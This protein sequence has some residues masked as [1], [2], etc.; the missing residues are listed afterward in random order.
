MDQRRADGGAAT[1]LEQKDDHQPGLEDIRHTVQFATHVRARQIRQE[2]QARTAEEGLHRRATRRARDG[3]RQQQ[4]QPPAQTRQGRA[5]RRGPAPRQLR[6][7]RRART[8][9]QSL[10]AGI[11]P[12]VRGR[13]SDAAEH[14]APAARRR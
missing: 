6:A 7:G 14:A 10:L 11:L 4:Q 8:H 1:R 9:V 12:G 3:L 2:S 5:P 13:V